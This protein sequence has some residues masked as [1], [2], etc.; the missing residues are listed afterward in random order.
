MEWLTDLEQKAG[1][2][3]WSIVFG[4]ISTF[5][6][7]KT[8]TIWAWFGA[9][10]V[11]V[12]I[13]FLAASL[14]SDLGNSDAVAHTVAAVAALTSQHII[15]AIVAIGEWISQNSADIFEK[16]IKSLVEKITKKK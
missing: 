15:V 9:F 16:L 2:V 5:H 11:A 1:F 7:P 12:P 4:L 10:I 14:A 8:R 13:G 3:L 6:P